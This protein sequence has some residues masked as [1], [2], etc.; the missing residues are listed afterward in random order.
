MN[1]IPVMKSSKRKLIITKINSKIKPYYVTVMIRLRVISVNFFLR[2]FNYLKLKRL[3]CTS[4]S[5]SPIVGQ[6][7]T[8][9]GWNEEPIKRGNGYVMDISEVPMANGRGVS[10]SDIDSL[11]KSK[12]SGVKKIKR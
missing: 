2:N 6:Q 9:V 1:F 10:D 11:L 3:I 8:L 7:L 12:N 5:T 4:Y